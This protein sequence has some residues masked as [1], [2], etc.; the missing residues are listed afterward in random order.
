MNN[1]QIRT[2]LNNK[3]LKKKTNFSIIT[4]SRRRHQILKI[5][6]KLNLGSI[7]LNKKYETLSL[8]KQNIFQKLHLK[9]L[10]RAILISI[11]VTKV[12]LIEHKSVT[13]EYFVVKNILDTKKT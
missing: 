11:V 9:K 10:C 7:V 4:Y 5:V 6:V 12:D 1:N 13:V 8:R 2:F 3:Y